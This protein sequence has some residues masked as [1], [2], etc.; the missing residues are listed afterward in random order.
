[1]SHVEL[2]P[3]NIATYLREPSIERFFVA[4]ILHDI[5]QLVLCSSVPEIVK[6]MTKESIEKGRPS[7]M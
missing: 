6:K 4:G 3:G 7:V 5:G 2:L 1:M